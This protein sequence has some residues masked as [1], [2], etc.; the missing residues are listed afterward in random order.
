[1][2]SVERR[3]DGYKIVVSMGYDSNGKQI[4]K[5]T[6]WK[7]TP[8]M[9][10]YQI[11]KALE[12]E[13]VIF[14]ES[15]K[16][17]VVLKGNVKFCDFV[18]TWFRDHAEPNLKSTTIKNYRYL[19]KRTNQAIGHMKLDQIHPQHLEAFYNDLQNGSYQVGSCLQSVDGFRELMK[20]KR[21]TQ[22]RITQLSGLSEGTLRQLYN[23]RPV[24]DETANRLAKALNMD[25]WE[26]FVKPKGMKSLSAK[27]IK[28]YHQFISSVLST[29]VKWELIFSNP[30]DRVTIPKV[31]R[32][33][34]KY[35][36]EEDTSRLLQ[37]LEEEDL[38]HKTIIYLLIFSGMRRGELCGLEWSDVDFENN[39]I[40]IQ[41]NSLYTPERGLYTDSCKTE[42][43]VRKIHVPTFIIGMLE[44]YK[45]WQLNQ[46][47]K[48]ERIF[49]QKNGSPIF[50]DGITSWFRKFMRKSDLPYITLHSLRHTS[51]TLLIAGGADIQTVS[52][53]LGHSKTSTTLDVYSHTIKSADELASQ[54]LEAMLGKPTSGDY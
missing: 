35:L 16:S 52:S 43:S 12:R 25:K 10:K 18:E 30:C 29:A 4:K 32:K 15:C 17:G 11:E 1:M 27:T 42:S 3:K 13:K 53:R 19:L 9:T 28:E 40:Q 37:L 14:E 51:A 54:T 23:Q 39:Q 21:L 33:E 49:T 7:P 48:S 26:L 6:T 38:K 47:I 50:P 2:A 46:G 5:S 41:R 22:K 34:A 20:S 31:P 8:G 24:S 45:T 36:D 44:E